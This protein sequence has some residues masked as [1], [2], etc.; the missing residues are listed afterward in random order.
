MQ[1]EG[2][3]PK[4][5]EIKTERE[6]E[7]GGGCITCT[8]LPENPTGAECIVPPVSVEAGIES[9][10][11]AQRRASRVKGQSNTN[12]QH[13]IKARTPQR[14]KNYQ[15]LQPSGIERYSQ[16]TFTKI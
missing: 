12:I 11:S 16:D 3:E 14:L 4:E 1:N 13:R 15:I 7:K 5:Q 6:K 9:G 8:S 10:E 2:Q